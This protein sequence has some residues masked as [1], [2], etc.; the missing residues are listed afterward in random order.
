M[1][2]GENRGYIVSKRAYFY[3]LKVHIVTD[4]ESFID[5]LVIVCVGSHDLN[6]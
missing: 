5:E 1:L 4:D 2:K 6:G 3:G